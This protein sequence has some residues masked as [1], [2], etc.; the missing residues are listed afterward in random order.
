MSAKLGAE[1]TLHAE[2]NVAL[3]PLKAEISVEAKRVSLEP[4]SP[5]L[6]SFLNARLA[7]GS[8]GVTTK[9]RLGQSGANLVYAAQGDVVLRRCFYLGRKR[10][11][12]CRLERNFRARLR[13]SV[14]A[15]KIPG[16]GSQSRG[17]A[18]PSRCLGE[19]DA[20]HR[21]DPAPE[22]FCAR[23]RRADGNFGA[24]SPPRE[25]APM[26]ITIDKVG[27][28]GAVLGLV[29]L[30]VQPNVKFNLDQ[31]SGTVSEL[32]SSALTRAKLDLRGQVNGTSPVTISGE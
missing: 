25:S 6:E 9:V 23:A 21:I 31:L 19:P 11:G 15:R 8:A 24:A 18:R 7:K 22:F 10:Y 27:L 14:L 2:G 16:D 30:S 28:N 12:I 13:L 29:D 5:Y 32:S 3:Q 1:T 17:A 20:Q 4:F 26:L